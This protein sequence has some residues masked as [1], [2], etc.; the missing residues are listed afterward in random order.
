[1]KTI[2]FA[3]A[4]AAVVA[5]IVTPA[6]TTPYQSFS[7]VTTRAALGT[8]VIRAFPNAT[9]PSF[10][11]L[12][13]N[14]GGDGVEGGCTVWIEFPARAGTINHF[15]PYGRPTTGN[16]R[17]L[18]EGPFLTEEQQQDDE[19][20]FIGSFEAD[21]HWV[22]VATRD[23]LQLITADVDRDANGACVSGVRTQFTPNLVYRDVIDGNR[24]EDPGEVRLRG[25][26]G[27]DPTFTLFLEFAPA[28][29]TVEPHQAGDGREPIVLPTDACILWLQFAE[30]AFPVYS[31][32]NLEHPNNENRVDVL[33]SVVDINPGIGA[34]G[35]SFDG[36]LSWVSRA[37]D[38][39][40][41][42]LDAFVALTTQ[43]AEG[44]NECSANV[45]TQFAT[46]IA[47]FYR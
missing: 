22:A 12:L 24:L 1:M 2:I 7:D 13:E 11:L 32:S 42:I 23:A 34:F 5:L 8:T 17:V 47:D 43:G 6:S 28:G 39:S 27:P 26:P 14:T 16:R 35:S 29:A 37:T 25:F 44:D 21:Q 10:R 41:R 31:F 30:D 18:V 3:T 45:R 38:E 9:T 20:N 33:A 19:G 15:G 40:F 46:R 4:T 36:T